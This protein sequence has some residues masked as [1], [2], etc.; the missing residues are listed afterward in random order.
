MQYSF[1]F[2]NVGGVFLSI[3]MRVKAEGYPIYYYKQKGMTKGREDTGVGILTKSEMTDDYFE[4]LNKVPKEELIILIDDNGFG[5]MADFLRKQGYMVIGGG[6]FADKIEYERGLGMKIMKGIGLSMPEEHVF[7]SI[8][9]ALSFMESEPEDARYVFKPEGEEFAGS[10]K[11]Y[12]GKNKA[13]LIG[14]MKWIKNDCVEKHYSVEKFILQSFID[15]EEADF[16]GY[17]N[18]EKFMKGICLMDIEEKKSGDGNKGEAT[19]CMGNIILNVPGSPYM[20]Y[21]EKL[22]PLF[23]KVGYVG[24]VSINNIFSYTDGKPYGLEFTP[25]FGWDS[26]LTELAILHASGIKIADFYIAL[27]TKKEFPFPS[28]SIGCGVRV[29]TGSI[30]LEKADVSGRYFSFSKGL[31]KYLWFYSCSYKSGSF[32]IED[33]PVLLA[34]FVTKKLPQAIQGVYKSILKRLNVPDVYYRMEIGERADRV[35]KFLR[36]NDWISKSTSS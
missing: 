15:G 19:G 2:I 28:D 5:D 14:Y 3:A 1:L 35:L 13:D 11:T 29:Y 17:F 10:S 25:R 23:K 24:E 36:K 27:V 31:M 7:N 9:E 21:L 16:A 4:I 18:G 20:Q 8:E 34:Q 12:T 32:C 30:S 22:T 6:A 26:H 33:N